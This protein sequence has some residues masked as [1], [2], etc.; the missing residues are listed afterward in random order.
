MNT[1]NWVPDLFMSRVEKD[2]PWTLFSPDETPDLHDLYGAAFKSA[3]EA[4]E[5]KAAREEIRVFR[6]VRALDLWRRILTML[7]ETGHP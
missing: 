1:A 6:T 3:Y 2:E 5:A 4:Y 7:F